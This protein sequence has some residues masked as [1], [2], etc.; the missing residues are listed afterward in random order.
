MLQE[1]ITIFT[2]NLFNKDYNTEKFSKVSGW[3]YNIEALIKNIASLT[4]DYK[5]HLDDLEREK[6]YYKKTNTEWTEKNSY[7][8]KD[9]IQTITEINDWYKILKSK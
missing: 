9:Y 3:D 2:N 1:L 4:K 7:S 8:Y 6:N 5:R